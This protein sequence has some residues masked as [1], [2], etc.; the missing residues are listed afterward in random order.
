M[1]AIEAVTHLAS[2]VVDHVGDE[3]VAEKMKD[4]FCDDPDYWTEHG[5]LALQ[6]AAYAEVYP[7]KREWRERVTR[8]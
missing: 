3:Q 4:L 6:N 7:V 8:F 2:W 5:W 1:D